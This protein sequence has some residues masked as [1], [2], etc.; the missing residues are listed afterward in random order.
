VEIVPSENEVVMRMSKMTDD[1]DD[2]DDEIA[3]AGVAYGF[4]TV[5]G[6]YCMLTKRH[7]AAWSTVSVG[8]SYNDRF[9][10][11]LPCAYQ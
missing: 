5:A 8:V 3:I 9:V 4:L 1:E 10:Q 2:N 11:H 6:A 7:R